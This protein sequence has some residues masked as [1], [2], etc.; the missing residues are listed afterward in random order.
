MTIAPASTVSTAPATTVL[1][2]DD[3]PVF[4]GALATVLAGRY[5]RVDVASGLGE[6]RRC[7]VGTQPAVVVLDLRL[8]GEDGLSLLPEIA[9]LAPAAR[10][11]VLSGNLNPAQADRARRS[12]AHGVV[13]KGDSLPLLLEAIER[14]A[15]GELVLPVGAAA[16]PEELL[17]LRE[18]QVLQHLAEGGDVASAARFLGLSAHTVRDHMKCVRAKLGAPTQTGAVVEGVRRGLVDVGQ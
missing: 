2:V 4:A 16:A 7:L 12:G 13:S 8:D 14:V 9:R 10:T 17:T 3:H 6:A 15:A 11:L 18:T 5:D 1:L